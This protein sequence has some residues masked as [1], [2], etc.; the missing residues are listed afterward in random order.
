[1]SVNKKGLN[2]HFYFYL[3]IINILSLFSY[4]FNT[5]FNDASLFF[6]IT[7]VLVILEIFFTLWNLYC[8]I[9]HNLKQLG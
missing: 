8:I 3:K 2:L 9:L 5:F 7:V 4:T 6:W 1:M